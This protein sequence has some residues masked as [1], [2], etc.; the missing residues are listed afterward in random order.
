M[1]AAA[2]SSV[3][4]SEGKSGSRAAGE[5]MKVT[6]LSGFLG[7]GKTTLMRNVL[8]Q[9]REEQLSIAVIVNDMV[10]KGGA[11]K[12]HTCI[13][14]VCV[15]CVLGWGERAGEGVGEGERC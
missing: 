3:G 15:R 1:G 4:G 7:A 8:R 2:G 10:R 12:R 9:A 5:A 6:L 13:E 14:W 11:R